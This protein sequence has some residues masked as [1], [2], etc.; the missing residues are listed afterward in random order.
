MNAMHPDTVATHA[1]H[2]IPFDP[3]SGSRLERFVFGHRRWLLALCL[4]ITVLLG[5]QAAR[6]VPN[7]S[8]DG[9]LPMNH[10]YLQNYQAE[11]QKL[12]SQA[13]SLRIVVEHQDSGGILDARYLETLRHVNDDVFLLDGVVRGQLKSLW[14]P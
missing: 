13:N 4:L 1:E 5:W 7:A 12:M 3:R 11:R 6:I 9:M 2:T 14:T 10:P 8:F